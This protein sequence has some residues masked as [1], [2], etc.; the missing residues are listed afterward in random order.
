[1]V[2]KDAVDE[3][4][5]ELSLNIVSKKTSFDCK[6]YILD[7]KYDSQEF[8]R[9]WW[10]SHLLEYVPKFDLWRNFNEIVWSLEED[11]SIR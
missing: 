5:N 11:A 2:N 1:M 7:Q 10:G 6:L 4:Y 3:A 8:C 9:W